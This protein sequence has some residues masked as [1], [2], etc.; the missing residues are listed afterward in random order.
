[1]HVDSPTEAVLPLSASSQGPAWEFLAVSSSCK[2]KT[3]AITK[4]GLAKDFKRWPEVA[5]LVNNETSFS[6]NV[7]NCFKRCCNLFHVH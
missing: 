7:L 6:V 3:Q 1:M 5:V 4:P 2:T